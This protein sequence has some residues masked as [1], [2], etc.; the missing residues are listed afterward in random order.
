MTEAKAPIVN[1]P[2]QAVKKTT[3]QMKDY[4]NMM[5]PEIKKVLPAMVTP[6]R[7]TRITLN[8]LSANPKLKECTPKSFLGA[9][10]NAAQAGLE[11]NTP[12][13]EAYL[14]PFKNKG[15]LECQ[16]QI[17]YKGMIALAH[18]A[19]TNVDAHAVYENDIFEY[20]YGLEPKLKHIPALTGRGDP[21]AYYAIW[22]NGNTYGF[23]VMS[24]EDIR[25]HAQKYSKGYATGSSPWQTD[26]DAMAKKTV[27]K[28][29]LKYAPL[30]VE[31]QRV[32][33]S[34]ET[35]KST[36]AEN[37]ADVADETDFTVIFDGETGEVI[38]D[39]ETA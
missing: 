5:M 24:H 4:V 7:F 21:I 19:G 14:I 22:K 16:F 29:A 33:T 38:S 3:P 9:M 32:M 12:L 30:A 8:A 31:E 13:G 39:G 20:E 23:I 35:I 18:R 28:Q 6:E 15:T 11:P 10:M 34:D 2:N 17:G 37:M 1:K 25:K 26:F 27:L 36:L